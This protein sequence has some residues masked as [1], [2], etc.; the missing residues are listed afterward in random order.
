MILDEKELRICDGPT[1]IYLAHDTPGHTAAAI[2][3][4]GCD[5]DVEPGDPVLNQADY[6]LPC[7]RYPWSYCRCDWE[8]RMRQRC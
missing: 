2:G 5:K 1:I 7:P 8:E 4:R 6:H 3:K